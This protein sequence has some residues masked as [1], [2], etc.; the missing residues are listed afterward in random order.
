MR[1]IKKWENPNMLGENK[2]TPTTTFNR[3]S[4]VEKAFA[5]K[6]DEKIGFLD[7]NGDWHFELY[8]YPELV[9]DN[10]SELAQQLKEKATIPVP[11]TWQTQGYDAMHYTDVL[12]PFPINPP[13][14]PTEN[15]T[16]V[17]YRQFSFDT[18]SANDVHLLFEGVSSYYECYLNG[19]FVGS[20]KG[21][22]ME[23]TFS[24]RPL[25]QEENE[26]IVKVV[27]W[28]DGT[29]LEDQDM[30]WLSGIFRDVSL[31]EVP[32]LDVVDV[33]IKTTAADETYEDFILS[34]DLKDSQVAVQAT[35]YDGTEP[36]LTLNDFEDG[37]SLTTVEKPKKWNAEEP[38]LY[39]LILEV[40]GS[41]FISFKVGFR[42]VE[43]TDN[44][45]K[46][47]G[48][49]IFI[50]GVNRHDFMPTGGMTTTLEVM[51]DDIRLMK[52]H[53]MNAVRT[54]HYPSKKEFYD[55]CDQYGL[56]VIDEADLEC[57]GFENTGDYTWISDNSKWKQ[58]YVDRGV[59]MVQRDYNHPSIIM[60]SLGNESAAGQ[61]FA[62]MYHAMKTLD[63]RPIHYEGD[64]QAA[65][66]DV[67]STM[68]S[69]LENLIKI[70]RD[71]EG[72][73]PH[74]HCEYGHAMGNG[75]GGLQEY[76]D[77]MRKYDRLQGGF[78]WEW[79]DHGIKQ[80]RNGKVT[81]FYGGDFGDTPNNSNFCIDGLLMPNRV[82]SPA[83]AEY[84]QVIAPVKVYLEDQTLMIKN[85][86]DFAD[87]AGTKLT[88][89]FVAGR[90][91]IATKEISLPSI[92]SFE[93]FA[94]DIEQPTYQGTED[95]YLNLTF[96]RKIPEIGENLISNNQF[97]LKEATV[98]PAQV[99][100]TKALSLV[101]EA[102]QVKI[103]TGNQVFIFS[104][105]T[106]KLLSVTDQ[107]GT[108]IQ[109]GLSFTLWRAPIDNDMYKTQAWKETYFLH[110]VTEQ[111][112]GVEV[113]EEATQIVVT[114]KRYASSVNQ[115]WGYHI[116]Q[117]YTF[118]Q[119]GTVQ[120]DISA[121]TFL[122]GS[123]VPEMLP[124][125]GFDLTLDRSLNQVSWYGNGPGESYRDSLAAV[126]MGVF[127][128]TVAEMHTDYIFPQ[129]N[130]ART[131]VLWSEI[132]GEGNRKVRFDFAQPVT[133]TAHDYN[134][135]Q[136]EK[137]LH[138]DELVRDNDTFITIDAFHSGL[139]SN[140]CGQEQYAYDKARFEDFEL[141]FKMTFE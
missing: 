30:W 85:L 47:N 32:K 52:Q 12:Y 124:R 64:R 91:V 67:Y 92:A 68:Y 84:K 104:K 31:F 25:L 120:T 137:A 140:S 28:S 7:L 99:G 55:L 54:A 82:P 110:Q 16:G 108:L 66:S 24:I 21:S 35:L 119:S 23:S 14:V 43:I 127:D 48:Q 61:N 13:F 114:V 11:S 75:P 109:S 111:L 19:Q 39:T 72:Q 136:L 45:L 18:T 3:F 76:Q 81:Y 71:T 27:K 112:E 65:Y 132:R 70:G 34:V 20:N 41:H 138:T 122:R 135:E 100:D 42:T 105:I 6:N 40:A 107:A 2:L 123:N 141:S 10:F 129:E 37:I 50:N 80:E 1:Q 73:K 98:A 115:N 90:E 131:N 116:E 53:N 59:R 62:E 5:N 38:N 46:V 60:W 86:Y 8:P 78:I 17:Y 97:L 33:L 102:H 113:V 101:D 106:G 83:M 96:K 44:Q 63:D 139:G 125:V 128:K 121:K 15:P 56:Y 77:V 9:S 22:R 69:R 118:D 29:Y 58:A 93:T 126:Q 103:T 130:G 51:E 89:D 133:F 49:V 36:V 94:L 95:L 57:H 74:I 4:T 79:Y 88:L 134:R 87:L 117:R 26:L